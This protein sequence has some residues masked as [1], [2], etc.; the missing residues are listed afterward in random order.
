LSGVVIASLLVGCAQYSGVVR[1]IPNAREHGII[2]IALVAPFSG[3]AS[4]NGLSLLEGARLAVD[5][6]NVNREG[7]P[8]IQLLVLDENSPTSPR[9]VAA[10]P[11]VVAVVGHLERG[12]SETVIA[13]AR[14]GLPWLAAVPLDASSGPS[15][16]VGGSAPY[17]LVARA[18]TVDAAIKGY[19]SSNGEKNAESGHAPSGICSPAGISAE[20]GASSPVVVIACGGRV[21]E[22]AAILSQRPPTVEY[23]CRLGCD[24]P[25]IGQWPG[26]ADLT[27]VTPGPGAGADGAMLDQIASRARDAASKRYLAVGYDGAMVASRA[28]VSASGAKSVTRQSVAEALKLTNWAGANG[29]YGSSGAVGAAIEVRR[30]Y[31]GQLLATFHDGD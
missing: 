23:V 30:G 10:D 25:E 31:P 11:D 2:K 28:I 16:P 6:M 15:V 17:P 5:D 12:G 3:P 13:Y 20:G 29:R 26:A 9:D 18:T 14:S 8:W 4:A 21:G 22:V 7:A 1:S 19:L 27:Y 24:S